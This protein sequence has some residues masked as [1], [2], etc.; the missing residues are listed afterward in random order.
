[1]WTLQELVMASEPYIVCG[2]KTLSWIELNWGIGKWAEFPENKSNKAC[3]EILLLTAC[4][5]AFWITRYM[6]ALDEEGTTPEPGYMEMALQL[7]HGSG[8]SIN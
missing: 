1:M 6:K 8:F 2:A 3:R 5:H 4:A 7:V